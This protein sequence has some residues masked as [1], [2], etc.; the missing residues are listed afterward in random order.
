[1][2][3]GHETDASRSH[4]CDACGGSGCGSGACFTHPERCYSCQV[5]R[6]AGR[7]SNAMPVADAVAD[8]ETLLRIADE[9]SWD[10]DEAYATLYQ[11]WE[12]E[13]FPH[14]YPDSPPNSW[15]DLRRAPLPNLWLTPTECARAAFNAV[16][17]LRS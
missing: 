14:P 2:S 6:G 11:L 3:R 13:I 4:A 12:A 15:L 7:I 5:C 17:G 16:P 1:M 8:A 9:L 10:S